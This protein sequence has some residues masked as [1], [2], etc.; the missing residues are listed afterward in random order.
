MIRL[1][2]LIGFV[3]LSAALVGCERGSPM[4]DSPGATQ[5]AGSTPNAVARERMMAGWKLSDPEAAALADRIDADPSDLAARTQ[6]LAYYFDRDDDPQSIKARADHVLYIIRHHPA[7]PIAGLPPMQLNPVQHGRSFEQARDLWLEQAERHSDNAAVLGNAASCLRL[8]ESEQAERLLQQAAVL[9]PEN[10]QWARDL[11]LLYKNRMSR[12]EGA[13][14]RE[15]AGKALQQ[16]QRGR[17]LEQG[18]SG[19][20][21]L[22]DLTKMAFEAGELESAVSYSRELLETAE[23]RPDD[24]NYGNAIHD[25]HLVLGRI[26]L[27]GGDVDEAKT[28][29]LESGKTRGSPQLNSFG[30]S[31][32]LAKELLEAGE[33]DAVLAYLEAIGK[34]WHLGTDR[35]EQCKRAIESGNPPDFG[36]NLF[37]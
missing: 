2:V 29:L 27:Q 23:R 19:F 14:R 9:E 33:K 5:P 36:P 25:G 17:Q 3:G 4:A 31:L 20:Y 26:A 8:H 15:W 30:P 6:L 37:Y 34:F 18:A 28:R 22:N 11:G 12:A 35:L 1:A 24:W 13:Q 32:L 16:L 21:L 7:E 10:A